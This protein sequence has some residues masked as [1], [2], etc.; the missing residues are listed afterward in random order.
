M[1]KLSDIRW[2]KITVARTKRGREEEQAGK[3]GAFFAR[4]E[5]ETKG[6][7]GYAVTL[8][9]PDRQ[10][11]MILTFWETRRDM[12]AFYGPDNRALAELIESSR[13]LLEQLPRRKDYH[14]THFKMG[15]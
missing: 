1:Q 5:G 6:L 10:E 14:V 12:D 15:A 13:P 8:N 2:V 7:K 3:V 4:L 11:L 9:E